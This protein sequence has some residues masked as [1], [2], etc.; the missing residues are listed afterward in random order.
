MVE[1]AETE[2][3]EITKAVEKMNQEWAFLTFLNTKSK[4][5]ETK[6]VKAKFA[7]ET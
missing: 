2:G 4:G 1:K 5:H 3:C 7:T 6:L